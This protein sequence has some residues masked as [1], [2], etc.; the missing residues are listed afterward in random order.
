MYGERDEPYKV[1]SALGQ[2]LGATLAPNAVLPIIVETVGQALKLPYAAIMLKQENVFATTATWGKLE[3][4]D[5]ELTHLPLVYQGEHI[6]ELV[7]AHRTP[8]EAFTVADLQLLR[9]LAQQAGIAAHAV[10]LTVDIQKSRERLVTAREEERRR[11]RRDLHDGL[12]PT[13]AALNLQAG[14][15]RGL[16]KSDPDAADALVVEWRREI[17]LAI[18]DIRRL[19]Y[20]LRP[21]ALDELGL[22]GAIRERAAQSSG[23]EADA[24][25]IIVEAPDTL[26]VLPAATEVAAYRIVQEAL[27]NVIHHAQANTCHIQIQVCGETDGRGGRMLCLEI[28]DDGRGLPERHRI[29]VG[30]ISM[31]ERAEELGG[32]CVVEAAVPAGTRVW[33]QLLLPEEA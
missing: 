33:A 7:L 6:G 22:V 5:E 4:A 16:I 12:G 2:R 31:R 8:G 20:E 30:L 29:G 21:P 28:T 24:L 26:S 27:T 32:T 15:I 23:K 9:N 17:R 10:Q 11:L 25:Q 14:I 1:I 19:S 18:G 3:T 13:L